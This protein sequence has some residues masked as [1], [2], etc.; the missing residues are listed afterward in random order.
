VAAVTGGGVGALAALLQTPGASRSILEAVVPYSLTAL[1]DWIG[2]APDQACSEATARAMA[3]AAFVRARRLAPDADAARL[4]GTSCTAS[5][6]TDRPKRG[7]RRL[8]VAVQ[9]ASHTEVHS[10]QLPEGVATRPQDEAAATSFMLSIVARACGVEVS[11]SAGDKLAGVLGESLK[12][13]VEHA[14]PERSELL[15]GT[16]KIAA[17]KPQSTDEHY[18]AE[19]APETRAVFA[20]AFNPPHAGHLR[21]AAIAE[22]R[23]GRSI[24]W[25]LS[26]ANVDKPPLDFIAIR[27]RVLQL[28]QADDDRVIALTSAPTFREKAALFPGAVFVVG[29]DTIVRIG[30][31]R[32]Y[33]GD[34]DRRD[35]ALA[36]IDRRGCRFLMFGRE[37]DGRFATLQDLE[38]PDALRDLCEEVPAADF[39]ED[40]SSTEL[41]KQSSAAP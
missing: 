39:R 29:A 9:S 23:L 19:A 31:V 13:D 12:S 16:R 21:M 10:L 26:I 34:S 27:D 22:R 3:M 36:E 20:G 4:L 15:L 25:E 30:Q 7:P 11:I 41:R 38:L 35:E 33:G 5:L 32:Y 40:I 6:A 14:S 24:A 18:T 37:L 1:V 28:R 17:V 2:G 8:H